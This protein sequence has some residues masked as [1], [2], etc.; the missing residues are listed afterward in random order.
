MGEVDAFQFPERR[1]GMESDKVKG[2][3][4]RLIGLL[5]YGMNRTDYRKLEDFKHYLGRYHNDNQNYTTVHIQSVP[6]SY[7]H[8]CDG[9]SMDNFMQQLI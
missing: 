2:C 8:T 4:E 7:V 1:S 5:D 9:E 3:R 6:P